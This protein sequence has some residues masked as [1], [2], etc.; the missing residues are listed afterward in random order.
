MP[1]TSSLI[2]ELEGAIASGS[3]EKRI[4]TLRRV[5]DLFM[6]GSEAYSETQV[7]LF[8]DVISRLADRI[9]TNAR[10]ELARRLAPVANAPTSVVRALA[11]DPSVEVA[12]PVLSQSTRLT[13]QDLLE[14]A[15]S[16]SQ[17]RLLAIS[18]R[19]AISEAVS[20]VLVTRGNQEVVRSVARNEGARFSDAT[21]GK[22]V[23]K[24]QADEELA[25]SVGLRK[26]I[27]REQFHALVA[28]ASEAVFKRLAAHNPAVAAEID[29]VLLDLTGHKPV[30]TAKIKRDYSAARALFD[31][32]Q[33]AGQP[34]DPTVREFARAG[35]VE[36]TVVALSVL[37]KLPLD[38]VE[39]ILSDRR[40]DQE[41]AL[42]LAKAVGLSWQTAR[43]ILQLGRGEGALSPQAAETARQHFERLQATTAQRV[44]RFYQVRHGAAGK[45]G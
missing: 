35:K 36:E 3:A 15:N 37:C 1:G 32:V 31:L 23:E 39:N 41:L 14:C 26:D 38:A 10:I 29:R 24:S 8:D 25:V 17:D 4:D 34:I 7:E 6:V 30:A 42:I 40:T 33:R 9:E 11:R 21:F 44:V 20:D 13:E 22:L 18:R 2:A 5:T 12:A 19:A 28:K 16:D 45:P 43:L 27:P